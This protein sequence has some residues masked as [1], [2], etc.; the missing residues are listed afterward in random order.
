MQEAEDGVRH[1]LKHSLIR[2]SEG[3]R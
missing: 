3:S 2:K 1:T